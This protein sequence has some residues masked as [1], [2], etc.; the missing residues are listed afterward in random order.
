MDMITCGLGGSQD[1]TEGE[2]LGKVDGE[3]EDWRESV[4]VGDT[5]RRMAQKSRAACERRSRQH[6]R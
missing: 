5:D 3:R 4:G 1:S 2:K 6:S